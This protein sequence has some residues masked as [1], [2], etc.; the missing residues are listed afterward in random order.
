MRNEATVL[1]QFLLY[2]LHTLKGDDE[3]REQLRLIDG[4]HA[5]SY[6]V[7]GEKVFVFE[8]LVQLVKQNG[9][10]LASAISLISQATIP[11]TEVVEEWSI[12]PQPY[13]RA[14]DDSGQG[15]VICHYFFNACLPRK[16]ADSGSCIKD[17]AGLLLGYHVDGKGDFVYR[18]QSMVLREP[19]S[20]DCLP[21]QPDWVVPPGE[22]T[23]VYTHLWNTDFVSGFAPVTK[24]LFA[25]VKL[26]EWEWNHAIA[27]TYAYISYGG[28]P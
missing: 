23:A 17:A 3:L 12:F 28:C 15:Q 1:R 6:Q 24:S 8:K 10:N 18:G 16:Y 4:V 5:V 9:H 22:C 11:A 27:A 25:G 2:E 7:R 19:F 14:P 21:A 20:L 13:Y 26:A